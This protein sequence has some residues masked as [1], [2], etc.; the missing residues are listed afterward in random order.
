MYRINTEQGD[1]LFI[2]NNLFHPDE[3]SLFAYP[4]DTPLV[5]QHIY[6]LVKTLTTNFHGRTELILCD[7]KVLD[8][9]RLK[10]LLQV[11]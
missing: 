8:C 10:S 1:A 11:K 7:A 3:F 4:Y 9:A 5:Q 6:N 2:F